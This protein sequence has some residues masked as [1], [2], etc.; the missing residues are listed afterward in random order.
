MK[1]HT[2]P[3]H[4]L[5]SLDLKLLKQW[6]TEYQFANSIPMPLLLWGGGEPLQLCIWLF[7]AVC[8]YRCIQCFTMNHLHF[9]I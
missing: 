1:S 3:P 7:V 5:T 8:I 9:I 2:F 6:P 4:K